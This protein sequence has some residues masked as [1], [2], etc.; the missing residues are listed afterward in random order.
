VDAGV[1]ESRGLGADLTSLA[2]SAGDGIA[3]TAARCHALDQQV[4][5]LQRALERNA[6]RWARQE[7]AAAAA[8]AR[9][10]ELERALRDMASQFD[11]KLLSTVATAAQAASA[12]TDAVAAGARDALQ[13]AVARVEEGVEINRVAAA[14]ARD[15]LGHKV[16]AAE[17]KV[18]EVAATLR[19]EMH[20]TH[21]RLAAALAATSQRA[22][23]AAAAVAA[24]TLARDRAVGQLAAAASA[25]QQGGLARI[26]ALEKGLSVLSAR[27]AAESEIARATH[28][29]SAEVIERLSE[30][31]AQRFSD[32]RAEWD[33]RAASQ[34]AEI[35]GDVT[36]LKVATEAVVDQLDQ[37]SRLLERE[38]GSTRDALA[39]VTTTSA[40]SPRTPSPLPHTCTHTNTR[41]HTRAR[42]CRCSTRRSGHGSALKSAWRRTCTS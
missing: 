2:G 19:A 23:Q 42:T 12:R 10:T 6:A 31:T 26:D 21:G 35:S 29:R 17:E 7:E 25:A 9:Q 30:T 3:K 14:E 22:Q 13:R 16:A 38:L 11:A 24:E 32:L 36:K 5:E 41:T 18:R 37:G 4:A 1:K 27:Q 15:V 34:R 39:Q 33:M 40:H 28:V 20:D 8:A